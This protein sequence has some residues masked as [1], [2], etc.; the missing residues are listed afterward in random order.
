M[1]SISAGLSPAITSSSSSSRGSVASARAV[2]SRLR[3]GSVRLAAGAWRFL[4][5]AEP[6]QQ[7]LGGGARGAERGRALQRAHHHVLERRQAAERLHQL[8]G[9]GDAGG[10]DRIGPQPRD[11]AAAESDAAGFRAKRAGDQVEDGGLAGAV[12]ADECDDAALRHRRS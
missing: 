1:A 5:E 10:A 3:S 8:E 7:R 2:S 4:R 9:A 11:V 12:R 6:G